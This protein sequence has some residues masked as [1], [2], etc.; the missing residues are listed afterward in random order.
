M[1]TAPVPWTNLPRSRPSRTIYQSRLAVEHRSG[2]VQLDQ[3]CDQRGEEGRP[4]TSPLGKRRRSDAHPDYP[5]TT[6]VEEEE[7]AREKNVSVT[8][9]AIPLLAGPGR[10]AAVVLL[11]DYTPGR[12]G[13]LPVIGALAW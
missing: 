2:S 5:Q 12:L 4:T 9:L 10:I 13:A 6:D 11:S 7:A 3:Q 8:P 1:T